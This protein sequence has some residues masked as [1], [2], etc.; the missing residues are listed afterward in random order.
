MDGALAKLKTFDPPEK[1]LD[2][3][4]T[5]RDLFAACK[6]SLLQIQA[7]ADREK[8]KGMKA[9]RLYQEM[10]RKFLEVEEKREG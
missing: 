7:E 9:V 10:T 8:P 4:R 5:H 2:L 1:M 3:H 6:Q